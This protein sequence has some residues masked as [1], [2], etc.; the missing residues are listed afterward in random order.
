MDDKAASAA[1]CSYALQLARAAGCDV[2]Q[3]GV[4]QPRAEK[5]ASLQGSTGR[6]IQVLYAWEDSTVAASGR[7]AR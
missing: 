5:V 3:D 1:A 6:P 4:A 2:R 7:R